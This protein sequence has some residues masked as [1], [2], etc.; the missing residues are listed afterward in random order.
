[1]RRRCRPRTSAPPGRAAS[2]GP[3]A[4][5]GSPAPE[6]MQEYMAQHRQR[7]NSRASREQVNRYS[8]RLHKAVHH[9]AMQRHLNGTA[10]QDA[11]SRAAGRIIEQ[12]E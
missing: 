3:P 4:A 11:Y 8:T 6:M 5:L 9:M 12:V 1:L 7:V 2:A 10:Q